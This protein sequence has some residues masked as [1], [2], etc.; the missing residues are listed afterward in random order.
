MAFQVEKIHPLDLQPRKAVGVSIP[1][2]AKEVFNSTYS[3][4]AALKTNLINYFL[5]GTGERFFNPDLGTGLRALLFDQMTEDK[6]EE[7]EYVIRKG[8]V[9]WFPNVNMNNIRILN[10][11]D[12]NTV[13]IY[14]NY[15]VAQTNIQDE[16]VINFEQ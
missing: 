16:L 15:S 10:S 3:T 13:T 12:T 2:S 9:D 1:F 4:Q 8:V 11:P 6:K 5:T 14:L 7:I